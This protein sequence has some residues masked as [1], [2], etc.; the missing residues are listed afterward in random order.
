MENPTLIIIVK[1]VIITTLYI[2]ISKF[3]EVIC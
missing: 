1:A 3:L 2:F